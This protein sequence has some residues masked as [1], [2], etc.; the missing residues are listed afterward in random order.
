MSGEN[1]KLLFDA[2]TG[3]RISGP[4]AKLAPLPEERIYPRLRDTQAMEVCYREFMT[5]DDPDLREIAALNDLE[6]RTVKKWARD[7]KWVSNRSE[8]DRVAEDA[9][10]LRLRNLRMQRRNTELEK[11]IDV[12][13]KLRRRVDAVLGDDDDDPPDLSPG[14][15]KMLGDAAKAAS[16]LTVRA[17]GVSD[18][19]SVGT[20][21]REEKASKAPLVVIIPGGGA[22]TV[23]RADPL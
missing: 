20:A 21:E 9:E 11:Q 5:A 15:L 7:G 19:G 2:A 13:S 6:F 4:G 17:L 22:P 1:D 23:R 3:E 12:G 18:A 14:A 16:D 8:V 10:E